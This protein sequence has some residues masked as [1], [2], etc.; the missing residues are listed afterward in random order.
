MGPEGARK[1]RELTILARSERWIVV[2]KPAGVASVPGGGAERDLV[3]LL[4]R[5]GF[6]VA[7][8]HRLDRDTSGA[9]LFALDKDRKSVV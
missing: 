6:A 9:I 8:V 5:Q 1:A 4:A 3:E 2:D 7:P